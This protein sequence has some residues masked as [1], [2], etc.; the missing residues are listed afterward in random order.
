MT[1]MTATM[2]RASGT[3]PAAKAGRTRRVLEGAIVPT[4]LKLA[5]PNILNLVALTVI[6]TADAF[7]V[8][9][10]GATALTGVALV[11]PLKMLAR[12]GRS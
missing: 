2:T 9:W 8:G 10:L 7:F 11:F 3:P 6:V 5:A 1:M 4:L 12:T